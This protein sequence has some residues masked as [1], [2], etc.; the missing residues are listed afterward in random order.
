[1][2]ENLEEP[3]FKIIQEYKDFEIREYVNTVQAQ[4]ASNTTKGQSSSAHFREI[5]SYIFGN[6]NKSQNISMTAPVHTWSKDDKTFMAFTMP[7]RFSLEKLPKPNSSRLQ[8]LNIKGEIIAVLKFSW[9]SGNK[10]TVKLIQKLQKFI[11]AEGLKQKGTPKL[12]VYDNPMTT[13]PFKRR[14]EIHI[15]IEWPVNRQ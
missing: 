3:S 6:N 7:S 4:V 2:S 8:L 5:A 13:L 12:A 10:R 15:P 11:E 1:M 9:F 14:N